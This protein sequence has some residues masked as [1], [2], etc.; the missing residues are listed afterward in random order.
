[1]QN[2]E[3]QC[4]SVNFSKSVLKDPAISREREREDIREFI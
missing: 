2:F 1:M 3:R 4:L